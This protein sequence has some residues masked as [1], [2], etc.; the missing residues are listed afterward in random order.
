MEIILTIIV[1]Y[2]NNKIIQNIYHNIL[3]YK[4]TSQEAHIIIETSTHLVWKENRIGLFGASYMIHIGTARSEA[5]H[6]SSS[7][8]AQNARRRLSGAL[9]RLAY[10]H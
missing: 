10:V 7:F 8:A 1:E 6:R 4:A 2:K 5:R 9:E 3:T